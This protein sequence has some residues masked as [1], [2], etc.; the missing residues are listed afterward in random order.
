M[1]DNQIQ[2]MPNI[3]NRYNN[4]S[5]PKTFYL[6]KGFTL[7]ELIIYSAIVLIIVTSTSTLVFALLSNSED[8]RA[9]QE[10]LSNTRFLQQKLSWIIKGAENVTFPK[11][12]QTK[13]KLTI[14][15]DGNV[16]H[17]LQSTSDNKITLKTGSEPVLDL[18]SQNVEV[19]DF[20][21]QRYSYDEQI[22][23]TIRIKATLVSKIDNN[24]TQSFDLWISTK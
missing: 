11:Q 10:V 19:T 6:S 14:Y 13:T 17:T 20:V 9:H 18:L 16:N 21:V 22:D 15:R 3:I 2:K 4:N 12:G 8:N 1:E 24:I 23:S 5:Q 7:I